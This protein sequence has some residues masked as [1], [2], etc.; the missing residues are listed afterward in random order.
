MMEM[1]DF[2]LSTMTV[3]DL[4]RAKDERRKR[5]ANLPFEEKIAIVKKLQAVSKALKPARETN[6]I[7]RAAGGKKI[8]AKTR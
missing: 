6:K 3:E 2:D 7:K 4:F 8:R 1:E 5:L